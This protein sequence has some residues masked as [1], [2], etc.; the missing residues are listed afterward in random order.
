MKG[1]ILVNAYSRMKEALYGPERL[2]E[3]FERRGVA[4]D[5]RRNDFFAVAVSGEIDCALSGYDFCIFLDKDKYVLKGMERAGIPLFNSPDAI[6]ACDD[7]VTT[8]LT[9]AG[10]GIELPLTL[11][12][13][14]SYTAEAEISEASISHI[15]KTL[16]Y[17]LV[18]KRSYGS[19]GTGVYLVHD[20]KELKQKNQELFL[21]PHLYQ[22][23]IA[24]SHGRDVRVIVIG[25]K[26]FGAMLRQS[27]GEFRSNIA[28]GGS[29]EE[30]VLPKAVEGM[31]ERVA[32]ILGLD[33]CGIDLLFKEGGGFYVCEVNSNAFFEGFE[34]ATKKNV[35]GA[36]ADY[37]LSKIKGN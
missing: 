5:I 35:A 34:H 31:C 33:Y 24:S 15:E 12:G 3:D 10:Q 2:K 13:I 27:D 21:E 16:G 17:P 8:F 1:I 7:K 36:Y 26:V 11:P 32:N 19:C 20:R 29:A 14:F 28:L 22:Q 6:E 25:Q 30:Y 37:I 18:V 9:L 4:I 23:Y